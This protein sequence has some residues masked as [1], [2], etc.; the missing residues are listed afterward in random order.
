MYKKKVKKVKKVKRR[1]RE[2][3]S[4]LNLFQGLKKKK[5]KG[6]YIY[7]IQAPDGFLLLNRSSCTKKKKLGS[8]ITR[9]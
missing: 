2:N 6:I 8:S 3:T 9:R 5:K 1:E 4:F 7:S